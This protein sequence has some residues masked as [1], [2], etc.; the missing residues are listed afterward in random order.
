MLY[1]FAHGVSANIIANGFNV[2]VLTMCKYVDIIVDAL[3]FK[4]KLFRRYI[5]IPHDSCLFTIMDGIFL[6]VAYL[7][8]VALLIGYIFWINRLL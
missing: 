2:G 3:F 1:Q 4:D 6:H 5:F 8:F 7:M